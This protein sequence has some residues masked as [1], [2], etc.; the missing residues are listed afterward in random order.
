MAEANEVPVESPVLEQGKEVE[1]SPDEAAETVAK[2]AQ[3]S[4]EDESIAGTAKE[5]VE[6]T[7]EAQVTD[8]KYDFKFPEGVEVDTETLGKAVEMFKADGLK[9]EQA[10]KY[11]DLYTGVISK[12]LENERNSVMSN[13]NKITSDWKEETMRELG[14]DAQNKLVF[15]AKALNAY[16]TPELRAILNQSKIGDNYEVVKFLMKVG[17]RL[18]EDKFVEPNKEGTGVAKDIS[19]LYPS[20]KK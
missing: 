1:I 5:E 4:D 6:E 14:A 9:P 10:Q 19:I 17:Q 18:T 7:K 8:V 12:A 16:G 2:A 13:Y 3:E 20:M 15:V 11:V